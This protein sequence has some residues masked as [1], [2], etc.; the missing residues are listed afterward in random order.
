MIIWQMVD[1]LLQLTGADIL[2][3]EASKNKYNISFPNELHDKYRK[4]WNRNLWFLLVLHHTP[5]LYLSPSFYFG[6]GFC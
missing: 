1:W 4:S 6:S 3:F 5:S 2:I